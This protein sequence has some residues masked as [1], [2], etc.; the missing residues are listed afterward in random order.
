MLINKKCRLKSLFSQ[1]TTTSNT[2]ITPKKLVTTG[3]IIS[4]LHY[5]SHIYMTCLLFFKE[6]IQN[7]YSYFEITLKFNKSPFIIHNFIYFI[8]IIFFL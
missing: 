1:E 7:N 4:E 8:I 2:Y 3:A 5:Y 6:K